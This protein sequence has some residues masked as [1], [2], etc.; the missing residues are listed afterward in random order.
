MLNGL[1]KAYYE[2]QNNYKLENVWLWD[3]KKLAL[4]TLVT[5]IIFYGCEFWGFTV[6]K[7]S[8]RKI[9]IKKN[10]ATDNIN[11]NGNTI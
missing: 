7:E 10:L 3:K 9:D 8:Q 1:W 2:F 4:E 5:A 11:I 6:S